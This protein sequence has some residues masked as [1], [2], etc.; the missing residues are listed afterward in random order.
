MSKL[1]YDYNYHFKFPSTFLTYQNSYDLRIKLKI[2]GSLST[3]TIEKVFHVDLFLQHF[4]VLAS[5]KANIKKLLLNSL[6]NY[7]GLEL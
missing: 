1:W 4:N 6:I 2:I 5:E 3:V 7:K